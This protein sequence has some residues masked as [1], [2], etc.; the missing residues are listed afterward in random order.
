MTGLLQ[1]LFDFG[2]YIT[3]EQIQHVLNPLNIALESFMDIDKIDKQYNLK[4]T[5]SIGSGEI[6]IF[7]R[8]NTFF[9]SLI[10]RDFQ[11]LPSD[12]DLNSDDEGH[13]AIP[14]I[15][16]EQ[17]WLDFTES[18]IWSLIVVIVVLLAVA[19]VIF[20]ISTDID[21]PDYTQTFNVL[22]YL[23]TLFFVVE[24]VMRLYCHKG[25]DFIILY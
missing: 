24:L 6:V 23:F 15:K 1:K 14:K 10:N 4:S 5:Y 18:I 7:K 12:Y 22:N 3:Y 25:N 21:D 17:R 11:I 9:N 8:I 13:V 19:L 20:Q 2:F 16:W